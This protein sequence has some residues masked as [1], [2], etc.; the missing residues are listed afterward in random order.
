[1]STENSSVAA[2]HPE[3]PAHEQIVIRRALWANTFRVLVLVGVGGWVVAGILAITDYELANRP[4][5]TRYFEAIH[6]QL[7]R[8][9]PVTQ[10]MLTESEI[11]TGAVEALESGFN[12]NFS[13]YRMR[14]EQAS[15]WFTPAGFTAYRNALFASGNMKTLERQRLILSIAITG[16]PVVVQKGILTGTTTYAWKIQVPVKV[17]YQGA[18][19]QNSEAHLATLI[20][21]R[22]NNI[23]VPRGWAVDSVVFG[24]MPQTAG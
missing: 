19:Y 11:L 20:L 5:P 4:I 8:A 18:G 16:A 3:P 13:D 1:M 10:P 23:Q 17:Y 14:I 21:V 7:V 2:D 6:G 22:Q 24:P 15:K 12:M 9:V